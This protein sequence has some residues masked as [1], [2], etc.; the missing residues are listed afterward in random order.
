MLKDGFDG[1][2]FEESGEQMVIHSSP[3]KEGRW[4]TVTI[5]PQADGIHVDVVAAD[6]WDSVDDLLSTPE[7]GEGEG[8]DEDEYDNDRELL[9]EIL[10]DEGAFDWRLHGDPGVVLDRHFIVP[11][12]EDALAYFLERVD[13]VESELIE[14]GARAWEGVKR[15]VAAM[16]EDA[17][18]G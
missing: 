3:R 1:G 17:L 14:E 5:T 13:G 15:A 2:Y 8:E 7:L 6:V 9:W 18:E 4:M 16:R 10:G 12:A 11:D